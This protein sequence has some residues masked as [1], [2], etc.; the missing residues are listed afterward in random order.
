MS[1]AG[2][3]KYSANRLPSVDSS[4]ESSKLRFDDVRFRDDLDAFGRRIEVDVL[5]LVM[6]SSFV[7]GSDAGRRGALD[8][9]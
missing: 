4:D 7:V 8:D 1:N 3:S 6:S 9:A 2:S 5:I